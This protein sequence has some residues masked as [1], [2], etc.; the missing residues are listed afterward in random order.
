MNISDRKVKFIVFFSD[1]IAGSGHAIQ[2]YLEHFRIYARIHSFGKCFEQIFLHFL[3]FLLSVRYQDKPNSFNILRFISWNR[4]CFVMQCFLSFGCMNYKYEV[5]KG[6]PAEVNEI[7]WLKKILFDWG[8]SV[9]LQ[10]RQGK[11]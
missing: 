1:S 2:M 8:I 7:K 4:A 5:I 10:E 3:V 11:W 9:I 6:L